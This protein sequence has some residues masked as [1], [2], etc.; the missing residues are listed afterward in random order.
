LNICCLQKKLIFLFIK[1]KQV[2]DFFF[3]FANSFFEPMHIGKNIINALIIITT[4]VIFYG[5]KSDSFS[6]KLSEGTIEYEM[7]YLQS[8]KENPLISLLPT[9]MTL[10]IKD[11]KSIQ[12]VEGW[13][14]VFQM[15]GIA[16]RM[17]ITKQPC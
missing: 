11:D 12:K 6:C 2:K 16:R 10:K 4:L 3:T 14:G 13:M 15:A 7:K 17:K 1:A 9:T 8:E 5:C